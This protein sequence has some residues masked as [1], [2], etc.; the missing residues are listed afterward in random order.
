MTRTSTEISTQ[1]FS[2]ST[3]SETVS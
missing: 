3:H 2:Q 1:L